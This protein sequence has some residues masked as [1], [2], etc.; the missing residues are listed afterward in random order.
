VSDWITSLDRT[1]RLTTLL[2]LLLVLGSLFTVEYRDQAP[3]NLHSLQARAFLQGRLDIDR[4]QQ[5]VA[6]HDGRY[7]VPFPPFPALLLL[8]AEA[9]GLHL[10]TRLPA[11][12]LAVIAV[13]AFGSLAR[14]LGLDR[15]TVVWLAL[16]FFGG[17]AYWLALR[18]SHEV[19]FFSHVVAVAAVLLALR[20]TLG[21]RRGW[22]IGLLL[23]AAFLTRQLSIYLAIFVVVT[24]WR[25][26]ARPGRG[27]QVLAFAAAFLPWVA[28]YLAF[29]AARFGSPLDTGYADLA[30]EGFVAERVAAHGIFDPAYVVFNAVY[31]FLQGPHLEFA[32]GLLPRGFDPFG[33]SLI[34][35][36]PL[37]LVALRAR[38]RPVCRWA[39]WLAV[40]LATLHMLGY[41]NNGWVQ[42]NAQRFTLDFLPL[43]MVL[44]MAGAPR[45]PRGWLRGL[46]WYALAWNTLAL[47]VFPLGRHLHTM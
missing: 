30:L 4:P 24:L 18:Q 46:V 45:V 1:T 23:G 10:D 28:A 33:T 29:N 3:E 7:F 8:P 38:G 14:G 19:W 2:T 36:S 27:R 11:I 32:G 6:I 42:Q 20:E 35:A 37:V 39:A 26:G 25:D 5:D 40:G 43:V 13:L 15:P 47:V 21:A 34:Y 16:G 44:V 12:L 31:L 22:L 17:T 41:Y 9:V